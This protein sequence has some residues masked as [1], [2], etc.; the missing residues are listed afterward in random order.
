MK[1][2]NPNPF[3]CG[4]MAV[5]LIL[6]GSLLTTP[7]LQADDHDKEKIE[8]S[9][10]PFLGVVTDGVPRSLRRHLD[11]PEGVGLVVEQVVR[12]SAAAAAGMQEDDIIIRF[13][14]QIMVNSSQLGVIIRSRKVGDEVPVTVIRGGKEEVMTVTLGSRDNRRSTRVFRQSSNAPEAPMPPMPPPN[15]SWSGTF[16]VEVE[17]VEE[18][19]AEIARLEEQI[20]LIEQ[21]AEEWADS[22]EDMTADAVDRYGDDIGRLGEQIALLAQRR[23][24]LEMRRALTR[25]R[26]GMSDQSSERVI[27]FHGEGTRETILKLDEQNLSYT[28]PDGAV[29]LKQMDN[30][31][32][33]TA[34]DADGS[35]LYHG[36]VPAE[37]AKEL[38]PKVYGMLQKLQDTHNISWNLDQED[39][40]TIV[41]DADL[42][43]DE[44][45]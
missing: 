27:E 18:L 29:T 7:T 20:E 14:D 9:G 26:A 8:H 5:A 21:Q 24:V 15:F 12:N 6:A 37:P 23:A 31:A 19:E 39:T 40:I 4:F 44:D 41:I 33:L 45:K 13:D 28:G 17:S 36:P 34:Q 35:V 38:D 43:E 2:P 16:D 3:I 25:L 10:T 32:M 1:S 22:V 42:P 30:G 11:L